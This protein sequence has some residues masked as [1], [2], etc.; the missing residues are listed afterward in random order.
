MT[1]ATPDAVPPSRTSYLTAC[2]VTGFVGGV[3]MLWALQRILQAEA[4]GDLLVGILAALALLTGAAVVI[5]AVVL[6]Q[7]TVNSN[8][9]TTPRSDRPAA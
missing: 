7:D 5:G 6:V 8:T 3:T 4:S 9:T 1:R 2:V